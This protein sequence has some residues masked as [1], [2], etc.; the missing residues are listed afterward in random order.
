MSSL[1]PIFNSYNII[2]SLIRQSQPLIQE[3]LV[4]VMCSKSLNVW[5]SGEEYG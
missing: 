5:S 1:S 2:L 4:K 3:P